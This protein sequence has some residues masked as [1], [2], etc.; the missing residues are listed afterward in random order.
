MQKV[1]VHLVNRVFKALRL[2][3]VEELKLRMDKMYNEVYLPRLLAKTFG[4]FKRNRLTSLDN[5]AV[6]ADIHEHHLKRRTLD[7]LKMCLALKLNN[8]MAETISAHPQSAVF[9]G[10]TSPLELT[11]GK[12]SQ[13]PQ[14]LSLEQVEA[15]AS[16]ESPA[17]KQNKATN[18]YKANSKWK[19]IRV[20][21]AYTI[22]QARKL[23]NMRISSQHRHNQQ[24]LKVMHSLQIYRD[25]CF[26]K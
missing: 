15:L 20:L 4:V 25:Q 9:S 24:L 6:C 7:S 18:R 17:W 13:I 10:G 21:K 23:D 26:T 3:T 19:V 22:R 12:N 8:T 14:G 5:L 11:L 16:Y 2:Q 1:E